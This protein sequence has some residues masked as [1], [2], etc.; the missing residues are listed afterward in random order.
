MI[1]TILAFLTLYPYLVANLVTLF[2]LLLCVKRTWISGQGKIAFLSGIMCIPFCLVGLLHEGQ[3][4]T[5]LRLGGGPFGIEDVLFCMNAAVMVWLLATWPFARRITI[6]ITL[7]EVFMRYVL[8]LISGT[9]AFL[10]L[11]MSNEP[12]M[13]GTLVIMMTAMLA[14]IGLECHSW[15]LAVTGVALFLPLYVIVVG[16]E[17]AVWPAYVYSWGST[18]IWGNLVAGVP[19]GE[20]AWAAAFGLL[21]PL[22]IAFSFKIRFKDE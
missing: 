9:G 15:P 1:T 13:T 14:F 8:I 3:Y 22:L 17:F 18:T 11:F 7:R 4:W 21:W 10:L 12:V 20:I 19:I 6:D 5:P 16:T 2:L